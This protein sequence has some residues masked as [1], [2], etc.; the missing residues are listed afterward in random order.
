MIVADDGRHFLDVAGPLERTTP[1]QHL[2]DDDAEREL[3]AAKV[4]GPA[5]R[6]L[7]RHV[8][9]RAEDHPG[10]CGRGVADRLGLR[11]RGGRRRPLRDAEVEDLHVPVGGQEDVLGLEIAVRDAAGVRGGEAAGDLPGQVQRPPEAERAG[12]ERV[13]QRLPAEE[14]GDQVGHGP[15]GAD[16]EDGEDVGMIERRGGA[17]LHFESA[18]AVRVGDELARQH[19]HRDVASQPRVVALVDLAHPAGAQQAD[20]FIGSDARAWLEGQ[21]GSR[22]RAVQVYFSRTF[23]IYAALSATLRNGSWVKLPPCST[24]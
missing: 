7:G 10:V 20:D 3:V 19:L 5:G 4:H 24:K 18:K 14:L 9:D 8:P 13:P 1:A 17:R 22:R 16:V 12:V 2:V 11:M 21:M 23:R 15:L 6:L